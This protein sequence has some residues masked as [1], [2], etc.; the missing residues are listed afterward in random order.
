M[1]HDLASILRAIPLFKSV[2]SADLAA[3]V[4]LMALQEFTRHEAVVVEGHP[5]PG[6]YVV[7]DGKVAV[8][9]GFGEAADHICDLDSGECVGELEIIENAPCSASVVAHG[10]VKTAVITKDNL[11]KFLAAHPPAAV[12]VLRQ[13]VAVLSVRLRRANVSYASMKAIAE[14]M[15]RGEDGA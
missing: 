2:D 4:N 3:L 9:K 1:E 15:T 7:L 12:Q 11:E 6:L 14:G 8:M 13:M 5:P 10:D